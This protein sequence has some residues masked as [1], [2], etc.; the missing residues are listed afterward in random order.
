MGTFLE[1]KLAPIVAGISASNSFEVAR[2]MIEVLPTL[3]EPNR[4]TLT[5]T[6]EEEEGS[7]MREGR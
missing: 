3:S 6:H 5:S 2:Q 4:T 1:T 7:V